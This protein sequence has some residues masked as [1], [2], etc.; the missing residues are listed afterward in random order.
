MKCVV[1]SP[2]GFN[3]FI[4]FIPNFLTS[5]SGFRTLGT[6]MGSKSFVEFFVA[7]VLHADLGTISN[8]PMFA[9]P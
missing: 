6:S 3:H 9:D 1:W 8:F 2:H 4:P 7:K 5:N